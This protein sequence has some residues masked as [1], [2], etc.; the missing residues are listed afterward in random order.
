MGKLIATTQATLDGV[1]D[2]VGEWVQP[3]G[4]HA[5][6]SFERQARSSGLVLGRKTYEGLAGYWPNETGKW[7]DMVNPMPKFVGSNSLSGDLEWNA[8]LIEGPLEEAIPRLKEQV[9]GDLFMH[10]SGEFAY[11]LAE[12]T[13]VDEYEIYFN[14]LIWGEGNV[15]VLGDRG[16]VRLELAD[17]KRFDSGVVLLTYVPAS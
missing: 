7:A 1:I 3:G 11:A 4:D 12:R 6:Y 16:T 15:H 2:P 17:V 8:S 14:P 10:G 13:L 9:D 5:E